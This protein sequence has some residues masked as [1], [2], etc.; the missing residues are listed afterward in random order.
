MTRGSA[1]WTAGT[2]APVAALVVATAYEAAVAIGLVDL[3]GESGAR[4][5]G[6][7]VAVA[8]AAVAVVLASART[9]AVPRAAAL[10]PPVAAAFALARFCAYDP[11]YAPTVR[12]ASEG[13]L[14][15]GWWIVGLVAV[16]VL[17]AVLIVRNH[18]PVSCSRRLSCS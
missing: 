18:A 2:L 6:E 1:V 7:G 16:A 9:L 11:Y 13:G 14:V 17:A 3:G 4:P 10:L 12:R 15:P 8:A 5:P